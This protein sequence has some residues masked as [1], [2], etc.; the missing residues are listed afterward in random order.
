MKIKITS[1]TSCGFNVTIA[2]ND[3]TVQ[4]TEKTTRSNLSTLKPKK[5]KIETILKKVLSWNITN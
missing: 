2:V 4:V 3:V 1:K 5:G